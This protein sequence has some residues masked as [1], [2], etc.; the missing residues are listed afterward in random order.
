MRQFRSATAMQERITTV[1]KN[2]KKKS[3]T[4]AWQGHEGP[5]RQGRRFREEARSRVPSRIFRINGRWIK[6][7]SSQ[8]ATRSTLPQSP[9]RGRAPSSVTASTEA[10]WDTAQVPS[11]SGS[12]GSSSDPSRVFKGK[13]MPGHTG[14]V[15]LRSEIL[16]SSAWMPRRICSLSGR[17]SR[18][19][20]GLVTI[21]ETEG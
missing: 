18:P 16:R 15:Q 21:K 5:L 6:A 19:K 2:G 10:P 8:K 11:S 9:G 3:H 14:S 7:T 4:A 13:G 12:N 1:D 17:D 20:K